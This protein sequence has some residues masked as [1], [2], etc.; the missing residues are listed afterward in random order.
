M[1]DADWSRIAVGDT[2]VESSGVRRRVLT[3]KRR[4]RRVWLTF[5]K[6]RRTR[7]TPNSWTTYGRSDDT[8]GERW[9]LL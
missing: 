3:V 7:W 8:R 9:R 6:L 2:V 5:S 1:T 4:G